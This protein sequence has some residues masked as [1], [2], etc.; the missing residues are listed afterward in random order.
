MNNMNKLKIILE[1]EGINQ[2]TLAREIKMSHGTINKICNG[3]Y[4]PAKTS[5]NRIIKGV[6]NLA[7]KLFTLSDVFPD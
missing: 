4:D 7:N 1:N 2:I 6:N 3:H 5:K